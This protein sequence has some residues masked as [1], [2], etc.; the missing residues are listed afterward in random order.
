MKLLE[1]PEPAPI[2]DV[3][4][5]ILEIFV[6]EVGEV[7]EEITNAFNAWQENPADEES[8]KNLRR[9]F[10]TLKGSGRLVGATVIGE[11]GWRFENMLNR[12]ID[13]TIPRS[14]AMIK[15]LAQV[16]GVLPALIEQF[17]KAKPAQH[18]VIV[19]ISQ[20][21][22]FTE[23]KGQS[24]GDFSE[25]AEE[26]KEPLKAPIST[27]SKIIALKEDVTSDVEDLVVDE[28]EIHEFEVDV[29]SSIEDE[30]PEFDSGTGDVDEIHEFEADT[31]DSDID[32]EVAS[33]FDSSTG[34][35]L[36]I[37]LNSQ[38]MNWQSLI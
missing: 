38:R 27:E 14:D 2:D 34:E 23:T 35:N 15:L 17:Q 8:L 21:H 26:A 32:E 9:A 7:L 36:M 30:T 4:E 16:E 33:E 1:I 22:Q 10:H 18:D 24:L 11:L 25:F 5:E 31:E 20:V 19:L 13:G 12:L 37:I 3:D 29:E 6:E 28:D